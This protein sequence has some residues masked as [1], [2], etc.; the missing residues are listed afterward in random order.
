MQSVEYVKLTGVLLCSLC[1]KLLSVYN[2]SIPDILNNSS[3]IYKQIF[4]SKSINDVFSLITDIVRASSNY[5]GSGERQSNYIIKN[6]LC[7]IKENYNKQINLQLIANHI[8][9][10]SSYLSR[11][12]KKKTGDTVTDTINRL[13]IEKAKELLLKSDIKSYEVAE[14]IGISD[15]AYFSYVFKKYA[16]MSPKDYKESNGNPV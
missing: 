1:S 10:N 7:Y 4:L 3:D 16:G 9:M 14:M 12:Y 15:S 2:V 13:R 8:H 11:L 6:V 5:L